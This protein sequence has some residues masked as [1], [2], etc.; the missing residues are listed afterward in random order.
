MESSIGSS[1]TVFVGRGC[2]HSGSPVM[3]M[4]THGRWSLTSDIFPKLTPAEV[5]K[6]LTHTEE[7]MDHGEAPHDHS[8]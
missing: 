1:K 7:P 8:R 5:Q 2:P 3:T 4:N 6:V